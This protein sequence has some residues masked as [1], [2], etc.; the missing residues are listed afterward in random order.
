MVKSMT[1]YA[2]AEC[3]AEHYVGVVEIRCYNSKNLDMVLHIARPYLPLEDRIKSAVAAC[4]HRGR[5][6]MRVDIKVLMDEQQ[7]FE[8]DWVR[9]RAFRDALNQLQQELNIQGEIS[10]DM[11]IGAGGI[12]KPAESDRNMDPIW[13]VVQ[14][15]LEEALASLERMRQREGKALAADLQQRLETIQSHLTQIE[16]TSDGM[17]EIYQTKLRDRI[18]A[19][20]QGQVEIDPGRIAQEAAF[21]ADRSDISEEIVRA[22][23]H[24]DQFH[25]ILA[26]EDPAGR[27]LN[28][29][30]QEFNREFNTMGAKTSRT[31]VAHRVVELKCELEKIR[32]Q[33][34]N[35]E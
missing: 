12:I 21:L 1:A 13:P 7:A 24:L 25:R 5:V 31:E 22:A 20:T 35:I 11:L 6:E 26:S 18:Q 29:L 14:E 33:V 34:Q 17:L 23:S 28:F 2:R 30:L 10:L 8:I 32:E 4:I 27:K 16:Q 9:A 19:L 3:R 15:G